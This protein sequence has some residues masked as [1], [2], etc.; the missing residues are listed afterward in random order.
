MKIF[1]PL[2]LLI[3]PALAILGCDRSKST[4]AAKSRLQL[5]AFSSYIPQEA[6][7]GFTRETGIPIDYEVYPTNEAMLQKLSANPDHYDVIQPSD[8]MVE[9]LVARHML[10]P[11]DPHQLPHLENILGEFRGLPFDPGNQF[12]VPYMAGTVGIVV[13]SDKIKA[14]IRGY[15]D[16][17]Q[18]KY[19]GRIVVVD[20]PREMVTWA[21]ETAGIPINDVTPQTLARVKP[22]LVEWVK[23]KNIYNSDDPKPPL[24]SDDRDLGVIYCGDAAALWQENHKFKYVLPAEGAHR[25]IDNLCIPAGSKHK[26]EAMAFI[27]YIL[28]PEVSKMIS[29]KFPYTNPNGAARKLLS[30]DQLDN[31]ASYPPGSAK[32]E[33]F[34]AIGKASVDLQDM[35]SE[36]RHAD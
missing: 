13:N 27:D 3:L 36:I 5:F 34:R 10:A 24:L 16:V 15:K 19:K 20:D 14:P 23:L 8:Y 33:I 9:H 32:L 6:I 29:D 25:F 2:I 12:S 17:F 28:R 35:M 7:D 4:A 30:K 21:L 22:T 26:A 18:E 1:R 11:L 31:P